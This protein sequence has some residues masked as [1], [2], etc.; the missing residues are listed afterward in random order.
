MPAVVGVLAVA[1][2][3]AV[4]VW[5]P[6]GALPRA[7][8]AGR[9]AHGEPESVLMAEAEPVVGTWPITWAVQAV[10]TMLVVR[11]VL[12]VRAVLVLSAVPLVR[13][14]LITG[15]VPVVGAEAAE[16]M[17]AACRP[18]HDVLP[19]GC[20][21]A[22]TSTIY[23]HHVG[24]QPRRSEPFGGPF[25]GADGAHAHPDG[26]SETLIPHS[27]HQEHQIPETPP[28]APAPCRDP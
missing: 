20:S 9:V 18:G 4:V 21:I 25:R 1:G 7:E 11:A 2:V 26:S 8:R 5:R 17:V 13:A 24:T 23:R 6:A 12:A 16:D 14:V 3:L 10:S 28:G 15:T 19:K 22:D 27:R